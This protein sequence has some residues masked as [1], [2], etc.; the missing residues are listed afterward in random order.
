[1]REDPFE[2]ALRQCVEAPVGQGDRAADRGQR[3]RFGAFVDP[4]AIVVGIYSGSGRS[5]GGRRAD[6]RW[7]RLR[8]MSLRQAAPTDAALA[9]LAG[10]LQDAVTTFEGA[11]PTGIGTVDDW[12]EFT[13]VR[14]NH[15][16]KFVAWPRWSNS[17][18]GLGP[19]A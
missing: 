9:T 19:R 18:C 8:P 12:P 14:G 5:T 4:D 7:V 15:F 17:H 6:R 1:M 13:A 3:G 11:L 2:V 10:Q 16:A